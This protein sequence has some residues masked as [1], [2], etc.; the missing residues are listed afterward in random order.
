M[1]HA[2]LLATCEILVNDSTFGGLVEPGRKHSQ[3]GFDFA[4]ISSGDGSIQFLLLRFDSGES[5]T[6]FGVCERQFAVPVYLLIAC[7]PWTIKKGMQ[8]YTVRLTASTWYF[9][10]PLESAARDLRL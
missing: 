7:L 5:L 6:C 8:P 3:F 1:G 2:A 10:S 4:L 9:S